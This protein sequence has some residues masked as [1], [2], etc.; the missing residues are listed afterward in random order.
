LAEF[1]QLRW[2]ATGSHKELRA[3]LTAWQGTPNETDDGPDALDGCIRLSETGVT[4]LQA[5]L[6]MLN[7]LR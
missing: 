6:Q 3:Q 7:R 5:Q 1:G 2:D 4:G